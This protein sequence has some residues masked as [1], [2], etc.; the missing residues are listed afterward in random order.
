MLNECNP[1]E[2]EMLFC[3]Y[4]GKE[5]KE[6]PCPLYEDIDYDPRD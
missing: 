1:S 2:N 4:C 3:C 6:E 5:L